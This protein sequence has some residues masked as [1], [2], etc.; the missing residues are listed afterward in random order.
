[1]PGDLH[2]HTTHSGGHETVSQALLRARERGHTYVAVTDRNTIAGVAEA[3]QLGLRLGLT[4]VSGV[5]LEAVEAASG[6][7]ISILGY[8]FRFPAKRIAELCAR[9][10]EPGG[11]GR[12]PGASEAI[13]AI[14]ADGGVAVL[15]HARRPRVAALVDRLASAGLD[16]V[17]VPTSPF[18]PDDSLIVGEAARRSGLFVTGGRCDTDALPHLVR[19]ADEQLRW[20]EGL[21]RQAG[22]MAQEAL[23]CDPDPSLKGGDIRDLVTRHDREIDQFL[24]RSISERYPDHAFVTEEHDH[25]PAEPNSP[26]WIIDPIDGTTNFVTSRDYF[27]VSVAHYH[28]SVPVFGMVY[29]VMADD[30]Y[31]GIAGEGAFING[32]PLVIPEVGVGAGRVCAGRGRA[33]RGREAKPLEESVIECSLICAHRLAERFGAETARL[34]TGFRAQRAFGCASLG[35]C[36]VARGT[37]DIYIS[38]SLSLWD[39]A[40]AAIVLAEAGGATA[41]DLA[42]PRPAAHA[43]EA[44]GSAQGTAGRIGLVYHTDRRVVIAAAGEETISLLCDA[45]FPSRR[46]NLRILAPST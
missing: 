40:A 37:L 1:M 10:Q 11:P 36:R 30:L 8:G 18:E 9:V 5:E 32:Q 25:P 46:P 28:G 15:A 21:V 4:V 33:G 44:G 20:A 17:E 27:A 26:I 41:V 34:A 22:R 19:L 14:K 23:L 38:C 7:A 13:G 35:I 6:Q 3:Q 43:A 29:D 42:E 45:L 24:T 16:G 39:Y 12:L 31:L 2:I